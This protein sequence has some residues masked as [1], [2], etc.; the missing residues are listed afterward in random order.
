MALKEHPSSDTDRVPLVDL[1]LV[2]IGG[3]QVLVRLSEI[4]KV[5]RAKAL[6]SVPMGPAHLKGLA[7][8]HG[9]IVCIIDAGGVTSLPHCDEQVTATTRFLLLRDAEMHVGIWVDMVYKPY[10]VE[11]SVLAG[12]DETGD[13]IQLI[14]IEG[15]TYNFLQCSKLLH[16]GKTND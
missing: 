3:Q 14:E 12:L 6:S 7:N 4:K 8:V 9:Q 15:V 1:L 13:S 16:Q 2:G 5:L 11:A 10:K